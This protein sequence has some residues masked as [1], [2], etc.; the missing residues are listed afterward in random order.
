[1]TFSLPPGAASAP[2]PPPPPAAA[3]DGETKPPVPQRIKVGGNVQAA[4]LV[5]KIDPEYPALAQQAGIQGSVTLAIVIAKDGTVESTTPV[6]GHPLLIAAAQ[7]AVQQWM[8]KPTLLNGD[9]VEVSTTV[10]V[11]FQLQ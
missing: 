8:Y 2:P 1:M 7:A 4:M 11:P 9:P 10:T 3:A 6:D 5:K